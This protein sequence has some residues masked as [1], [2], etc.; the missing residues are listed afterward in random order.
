VY[1]LQADPE[2]NKDVASQNSE[3]VK[4]GVERIASFAGPLPLKYRQYK[5]RAQGRT[6]RSFAPMRFGK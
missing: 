5:Q 4:R 3:I 1:D 2:E 6:M